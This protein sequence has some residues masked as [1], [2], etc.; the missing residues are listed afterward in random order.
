MMHVIKRGFDVKNRSPILPNPR[1]DAFRFKQEKIIHIIIHAS[2]SILKGFPPDSR[3]YI[4]QIDNILHHFKARLL[5][6][7]H[8]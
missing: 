5:H 3:K 2:R 6:V 7:R 8:A 4:V 1:S